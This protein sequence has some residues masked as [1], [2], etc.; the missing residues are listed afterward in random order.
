MES[1]E[2]NGSMPVLLPVQLDAFW[3]QVQIIQEEVARIDKAA[4]G[5]E[6]RYSTP[7]LT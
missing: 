6:S 4:S 2:M 5:N 3:R 1:I 7:G